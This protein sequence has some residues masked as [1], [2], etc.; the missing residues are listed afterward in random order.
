MVISNKTPKTELTHLGRTLRRFRETQR[1]TQES[2]LEK[3]GEKWAIRKIFEPG[4]KTY[5]GYRR[6]EKELA[7]IL[8]IPTETS[9]DAEDKQVVYNIQN[10]YDNTSNPSQQNQ[11]SFNPLD[12]F[13]EAVE[14]NNDLVAE[15]RKLYKALLQSEREKNELLKRLLTA[16]S[17]LAT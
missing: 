9:L 16:E 4:E 12:K 5:V 6:L 8:N 2:P 11:P 10:N 7:K 14:I 17:K 15:I 13:V 3:L 1:P